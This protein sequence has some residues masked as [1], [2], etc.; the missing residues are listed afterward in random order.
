M[1]LKLSESHFTSLGGASSEL[2]S[3]DSGS[4]EDDILFYHPRDP[5]SSKF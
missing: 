1:L 2:S 4:S 5:T 3:P